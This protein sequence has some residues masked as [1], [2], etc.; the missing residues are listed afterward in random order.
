MYNLNIWCGRVWVAKKSARFII[1][2][3]THEIEEVPE[4]ISCQQDN[5]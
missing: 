1:D 4:T 3:A 5:L 2:G